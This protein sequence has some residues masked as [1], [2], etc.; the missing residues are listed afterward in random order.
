MIDDFTITSSTS[1]VPNLFVEKTATSKAEN[2][3]PLATVDFYSPNGKILATLTNITAHNYGLTTVSIDN[4]GTGAINYGANIANNLKIFQKTLRVDP[5]T[6]NATGAYNIKLYYDATEIAGWQGITG[7]GFMS[8]NII[9]CPVNIASGTNANGV[10][11]TAPVIATYGAFDS[12]ITATFSTGFSGFSAGADIIVLP[13]EMLSFK[14]I[15]KEEAVLLDWITASE[16]NNLGFDIERSTDASSWKKIGFIPGKG[17]T[18]IKSKYS[19]IDE[20]AFENGPLLYY[21]LKQQD[22]NGNFKYSA[23]RFVENTRADVIMEI[24]PQPVKEVLLITT[25]LKYGFSYSIFSNDGKEVLQGVLSS[26]KGSI[27]LEN[28]PAGVYHIRIIEGNQ[29]IGTKKFVK[30]E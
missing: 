14:A 11:G 30:V 15:K 18:F 1:N 20:K 2:F 6:N 5:T 19:Y 8:A 29:T 12:S 9:K 27:N 26:N 10:Y 4:I 3:G 25:S 13:V 23:I 22:Y 17:T 16:T 7:N 24:T 28:L 21:R